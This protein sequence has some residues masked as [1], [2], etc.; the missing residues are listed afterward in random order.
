MEDKFAIVVPI[1]E[2]AGRCR[3]PFSFFGYEGSALVFV[4]RSRSLRSPRSKA[5][6]AVEKN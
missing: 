4:L 1:R 5:F 3:Q 2:L 6:V